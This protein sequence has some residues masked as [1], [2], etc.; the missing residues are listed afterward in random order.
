MPRDAFEAFATEPAVEASG[1]LRALSVEQFLALDIPPRG[2][3]MSPWLPEKGFAMVHSPRGVGKTHF[4]T[5]VA[6]AVASGGEFLGFK[7]PHPRRVV[8]LDGEMPANAMQ[9]RLAVSKPRPRTRLI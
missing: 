9:R 1:R 4:C 7:A 5:A 2:M 3:V 8:Y 6:Y